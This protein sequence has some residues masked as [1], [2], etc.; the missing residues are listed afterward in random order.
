MKNSFDLQ[1]LIKFIVKAK[2]VT[3]VGSGMPAPA[4]RLNSH[5]LEFIDGSFTYRDSYFGGQNFLGEEAVWYQD[6]PVWGENYY[7]EVLRTDLID[8]AG[9]G[10]MIKRALSAMYAEG[11]FLGGF[12][13]EW[14]D[15]VYTDRNEGDVSS[16]QG[17]EEILRGGV[18]VYRLHYHGGTII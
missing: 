1:E 13:F 15:L 17:V 9:A 14:Q 4:C 5:D 11:R 3:Y 10:G 12:R 16:F 6:Q 18:A 2:T 8:A 7:G